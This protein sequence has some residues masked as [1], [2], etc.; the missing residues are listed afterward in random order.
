MLCRTIPPLQHAVGV[1]HDDAVPHGVGGFLQSVKLGQQPVLGGQ[2]S[3]VKLVQ[4]VKDITPKAYALWGGF[5]GAR[6]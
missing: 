3:T 2:M 5:T 1:G 4:T 6:V